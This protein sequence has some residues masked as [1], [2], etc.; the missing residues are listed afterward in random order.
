MTGDLHGNT[1]HALDLLRVAVREDCER[2]FVLGDFGAWE[3]TAAGRRYFDVVDRAARKAKVRV[4]FLDG[5]H[6]KS[7]LL[8][9]LYGSE[10]DDEGFLVCRKNLRYAPR[11]H[12][13]SW[14]GTRFAAFG[15]AYSVDKAPRLAAE[16][17]RA[18]K[19][20]RRRQFGSARRPVTEGTLWF[21]EEQMT[22]DECDALLAADPTP[23][24]VLL[25]HDKPRAAEPAWNRKN[26]PEC[27]PN[28][29]RIQRVVDTLR[30]RLL[31]HG[32]LHFRYT[33]Q[34][35]G[36]RVEGLGA[37]PDA[38]QPVGYQSSDSWLALPL[39]Y[40]PEVAVRREIA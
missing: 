10:P 27:L 36:T 1:G 40:A 20:E 3:H 17:Q 34:L 30:P 31:L 35:G 16:A 37:D 23:V 7:S 9:E 32:H 22:D 39:P 25:T 26:L 28:Q 14:A 2:M 18:R 12:R 11:G 15:G 5:N 29:E 6:D 21:P 19:A 24:D 38:S 4:Y 33:D 8:H 13:W